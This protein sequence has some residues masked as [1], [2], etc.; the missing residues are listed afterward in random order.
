M[1]FIHDSW[2]APL[3]AQRVEPTDNV[4]QV[5]AT[6]IRALLKRRPQHTALP[7]FVF[8]A[9]YDAVQLAQLLGNEPLGL[10]VRL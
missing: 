3:S 5:A 10:L 8:D 2:S 9:G 6:Q 4:Q 7:I 1:S